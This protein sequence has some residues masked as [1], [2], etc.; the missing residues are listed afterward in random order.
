LRQ[1]GFVPYALLEDPEVREWREKFSTATL[2]LDQPLIAV[3][4]E[5]GNGAALSVR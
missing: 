1:L 5:R 4:R 3:L 2:A